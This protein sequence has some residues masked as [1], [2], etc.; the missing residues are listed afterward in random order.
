MK[1]KV[2]RNSLWSEIF[3]KELADKGV[4]YACISPG[5]RNT[6][7]T[8]AFSSNKEIKTHILVDERSNGFFA[9][10][11]AR[12]SGTPVALVCTSGTAV[13]EFYP[14]IIEAFQQ[15]IPLIVCTADRPPELQNCGANQTIHQNN[16]YKNHIFWSANAGLPALSSK[17]LSFIRSLAK[18]AFLESSAKGP[19]HV[20]FPFRKPLEP[21]I[22]TDEV[23][24]TLLRGEDTGRNAVSSVKEPAS[25]KAKAMNSPMDII[26]NKLKASQKC[27]ILTGPDEPSETLPCSLQNLASV[28]GLPILADGASQLRYGS[29]DKKNVFINFEGF[30]RSKEFSKKIEPE[31]ILHFGRT[32]TSKGMEIFLENTTSEYCII[33]EMGNIFDP[34]N[35]SAQVLQLNP[36]EFCLG[37]VK[38]AER[39]G[40]L[41][42]DSSWLELF[43]NAELKAERLKQELI[44]SAEFPF[45]G[46][47]ISETISL[48]P[49]DS[50]LMIS[51]SMPIRDLD[52][53]APR[54]NCHINVFNNRGAS[55]IDGIISTAL[56]IAQATQ[57]PTVLFTGDLA[58]YYDMNGLLA[59]KKYS[60]PLVVVLINNDGG[61][62]FQMLPVSEC[63]EKL[64]KNCFQTPQELDYS[65]FV[66]GYGGDFRDVK[67]WQD[68]KSSF[69]RALKNEGLSVLQLK[70]DPKK[71]TS[72][73]RHFW[74]EV[75]KSI[76]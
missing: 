7:L 5:S 53:F 24:E 23:N 65:H 2:N 43:R 1:I 42:K 14:A 16:I 18:K 10:G 4:K 75:S 66:K 36:G 63:D 19:V 49:Q 59:S 6:P 21:F 26:Y 70:T 67:S 51:N 28:F 9:L 12:A 76:L 15:N 11:L 31:L 56:G 52:Y 60:I 17:K 30:L 47:I 32:M 64:F 34:F 61:G 73:R 46:R 74:K 20:N 13:A 55:G 62:I 72:L 33:N 58:F 25:M 41:R 45:E 44:L 38:K 39:E 71:S 54:L 35:K 27:I 8:L 3:V 29:H 69:T 57:K 37:M 40:F 22:F 48:M 50:N 68:F